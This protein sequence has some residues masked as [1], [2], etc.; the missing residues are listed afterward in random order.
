MTEIEVKDIIY[1]WYYYWFQLRKMRE[2]R[3]DNDQRE[4]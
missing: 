2:K 3:E 4:E 1:C